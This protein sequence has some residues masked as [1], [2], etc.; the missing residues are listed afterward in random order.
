MRLA[1]DGENQIECVCMFGSP[2]TLDS[3]NNDN[4]VSVLPFV[5][6]VNERDIVSSLVKSQMECSAND[7]S[8]I[9]NAIEDAVLEFSSLYPKC[10][11]CGG[12]KLLVE[13]TDVK[14]VKP[15]DPDGLRTECDGIVR[16]NLHGPVNGL[17][18][19]YQSDRR[20]LTCNYGVW[21]EGVLAHPDALH[22]GNFTKCR[23]TSDNRQAFQELLLSL[24]A[25]GELNPMYKSMLDKDD[26]AITTATTTN[27]ICYSVKATMR[28]NI[29][30]GT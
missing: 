24:I 6:F 25:S 29:G 3:S 10:L 21:V 7:K 26:F 30:R 8:Q 2:A 9:R 23:K 28:P 14:P 13:I 20:L 17:G 16:V 11:D 22:R 4:P 18:V 19:A 15:S 12:R 27:S 5:Y 1:K